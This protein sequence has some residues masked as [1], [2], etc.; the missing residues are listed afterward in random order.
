MK[1]K[2]RVVKSINE[3]EKP[4]KAEVSDKEFRR[5]LKEIDKWRKKRLAEIRSEDSR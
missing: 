5:R 3:T 2:L 4:A 1:N